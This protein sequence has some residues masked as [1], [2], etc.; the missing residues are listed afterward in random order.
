MARCKECPKCG[1]DISD[2]YESWDPDCGIFAGWYCESCN[3]GYPDEDE[4][5]YYE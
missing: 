3:I 2:S 1:Q 5:D 4:T